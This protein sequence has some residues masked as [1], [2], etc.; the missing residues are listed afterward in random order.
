MGTR[1]E[2]L[3]DRTIVRIAAHLPDLIVYGDYSQERPSVDYFDGVL[4]FVDISGKLLM[5]GGDILKFAGDAL[6]A[7]WKVERKQ[8]KN[9]ITVVIKCSLEIHG[10]FE[11]QEVEEGLDVRV[12]IGLAAGHISMLVFG[13]DTR[14]YF[15]VIGQ[16]VDDVR[17]AQNMARMND[18]ILSP[19][20]W[21]LCDRNMIEIERIPDQRA[22]KLNFGKP[23]PGRT[24]VSLGQGTRASLAKSTP[25]PALLDFL[26]LACILDSDPKLEMSLQKYVMENI[27]KQI[28][29]KQLGGYLSE[30]R[31]VTIVFVNLM[32]KEQDKPEVIGT[33]IQDACVHITSVLKVFRGQINKVFMFDKGCSFLC[34]FGFPGEKAPD[35]FSHALESAV[36]IFDFCSQVH[37]IHTVSIG[38]ASGV[39]F[40]GIV[41]HTVRHEYTA[42]L[43]WHTSSATEMRATLP[44]FF[45]FFKG[46]LKKKN[47]FFFF[48]Q[49]WGRSQGLVHA[50]QALHH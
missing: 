28:D 46:S 41:G 15:L 36:D 5:F 39:V 31:P 33:A 49:G 22:V 6:L 29:D 11:A 21:Q 13:D 43:G 2:E 18:V 47:F 50:R 27:L 14:N 44:V 34:V 9:I 12:K 7:L 38:V 3:Q 16:A 8:L 4:M 24:W 25:P 23:K 35:E 17:L 42:C 37:K 30:L 20:C 10:L 26:R 19:N 1:R 45:F 40:C 48:L 32:F